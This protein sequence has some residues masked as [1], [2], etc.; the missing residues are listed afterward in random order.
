[1]LGGIIIAVVLVVGIPV[2]V[3][4]TGPV[5]AALLGWALK[6]DGEQRN[7]GSELIALNR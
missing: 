3:I 6:E 2:A 5:I 7:E 1:M 4:M